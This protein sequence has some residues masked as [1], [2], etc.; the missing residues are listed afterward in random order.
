MAE[1]KTIFY[2]RRVLFLLCHA[3]LTYIGIEKLVK[4]LGLIGSFVGVFEIVI[5]P[6]TM[7]LAIDNSQNFMKP[8]TRRLFLAA[9]AILS[10][11]SLVAVVYNFLN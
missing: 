5:I 1:K 11:I 3:V 10:C 4:I 7:F 8:A 2:L 6:G 9:C